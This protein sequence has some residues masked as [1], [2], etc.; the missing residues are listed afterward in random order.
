[1]PLNFFLRSESDRQ[2]LM[3]FMKIYQMQR[4]VVCP[5]S[6]INRPPSKGNRTCRYCGATSSKR[7]KEA[8]TIPHA[9]GN[10]TLISFDECDSCNERFSKWETDLAAFLGVS[11]TFNQV[12]AKNGVPK[13]K[14]ADQQL[15][16]IGDESWEGQPKH[17]KIEKMTSESDAMQID[18]KNGIVEVTF[19]KETYR[20]L[21]AFKALVKMA[22]A[23]LPE[24]E[25]PYYETT[26]ELLTGCSLDNMLAQVAIIN[27]IS[28]PFGVGTNSPFLL[29]YKKQDATLAHPT[30][31]ALLFWQNYVFQYSIPFHSSDIAN[32]AGKPVTQ[33]QLPPFLFFEA[34]NVKCF[35]DIVSLA[36]DKPLKGE[37][38]IIEFFYDPSIP[39]AAYDTVTGQFIEAT[40]NPNDVKFIHIGTEEGI[41]YPVK[42][43]DA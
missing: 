20:P 37:K 39:L 1:M 33:P 6:K 28:Y 25:L 8:H 10:K 29:L 30:H 5:S 14:S 40:L 13:F 16:V 9:L 26:R 27:R 23:I 7:W 31:V 24:D 22:Y 32:F 4:E 43:D 35:A 38:D 15:E 2:Q 21:H 34:K 3:K 42:K 19:T 12:P 18:L 11:R 17:V 41:R 36:S